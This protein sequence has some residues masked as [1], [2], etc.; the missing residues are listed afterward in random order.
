MNGGHGSSNGPDRSRAAPCHPKGDPLMPTSADLEALKDVEERTGHAFGPPIGQTSDEKRIE[1]A[2][3]LIAEASPA[4]DRNTQTRIFAG[5][6][7]MGTAL[8]DAL[9]KI[10]VSEPR[11]KVMCGVDGW[12]VAT[13]M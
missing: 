11:A 1:N 4:F 9:E 7:R 6:F 12:Y 8:Y 3:R 5:P 10:R 2:K 13:W